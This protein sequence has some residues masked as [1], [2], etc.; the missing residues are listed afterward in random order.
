M[1][2]LSP[3]TLTRTEQETLLRVSSI[4]PRDHVIFSLALGTG[5]R[6]AEIV[7]LNVGDV[8]TSTGVPRSRIRLRK[9]I[10]KG[11]RAGDVFLPDALG[12]KLVAFHRYKVRSGESVAPSAA[13]L[14]NQSGHRISTRRVQMAF[15]TWQQRAGFDRIYGFHALRHYAEFR[16]MPSGRGKTLTR[17]GITA[18]GLGIIR[19]AP[20]TNHV[21]GSGGTWEPFPSLTEPCNE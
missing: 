4:H 16:I 5:L 17:R 18:R 15:K 9:E 19:M 14:C 11:G 8:F 1:P 3:S 21:A 10:A 7:G 12:P 20:R 6:L 2:Y 13:L